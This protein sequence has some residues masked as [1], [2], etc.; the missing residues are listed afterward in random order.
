L[1]ATLDAA[2]T[3]EWDPLIDIRYTPLNI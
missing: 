2:V 3:P 1:I